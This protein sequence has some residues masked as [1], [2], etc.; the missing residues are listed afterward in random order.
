MNIFVIGGAGFLGRRVLRELDADKRVGRIYCLVHH[1]DVEASLKK[2]IRVHGDVTALQDVRLEDGARA[3]KDCFIGSQVSGNRN[4]NAASGA[5][6]DRSA[7]DVCL[8]LSGV[9]NGRG[10]SAADTMRVNYEG[11]KQAIEFCRAHNIG[12]IAITSSVN[13]RLTRQGVYAKS[14][15]LAEQAV[16]D[17]GLEYLIFR[18]ALIFGADSGGGLTVIEA[19]IK[20]WGIVPVFGDGRKLEQPI[21][22]GECA[23]M[24]EWLVMGSKWNRTAELLGREAMEYCTMCRI[25]AEYI[26]KRDGTRQ[27]VR[28]VHFPAALCGKAIE[29]FEA[30]HIRLP[31]SSE[32]VWHV[33]SD[34]AGDMAAV[35][36]ET[37]IEGESFVNNLCKE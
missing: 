10:A 6:I 20:K 15:V 26:G 33:D 17:S 4:D 31:I 19:F 25:M 7:I 29:L 12:R 8:V 24:M 13:V 11:V 3:E 5:Q 23:A 30:L 27:A 22:V 32:Q 28:F 1:K 35:Y 34:L 16:K 2:A 36:K 18:P 14:K 21:Y 37:G 9:T